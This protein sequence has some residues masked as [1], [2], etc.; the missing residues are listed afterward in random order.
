[1]VCLSWDCPTQLLLWESCA[2]QELW[3]GLSLC[4]VD[5]QDQASQPC[6]VGFSRADFVVLTTKTAENNSGGVIHWTGK[7]YNLPQCDFEGLTE[8]KAISISHLG[9]K[10]YRSINGMELKCYWLVHCLQFIENLSSAQHDLAWL[11]FY[12]CLI[13]TLF[14]YSLQYRLIILSSSVFVH[15]SLCIYPDG[16]GWQGRCPNCPSF[17]ILVLIFML[18]LLMFSSQTFLNRHGTRG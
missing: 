9:F 10:D 18:I 1:M 4:F 7:L 3:Q 5:R 13:N 17:S 16:L 2:R 6:P 11:S 14:K 8:S 15:L 12:I